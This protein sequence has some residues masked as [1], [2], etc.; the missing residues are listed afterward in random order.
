LVICWEDDGTELQGSHR[1][2]EGDPVGQCWVR[3]NDTFPKRETYSVTDQIRRAAV[4]IPSNIGEG[5]SHYSK[6]EFI[7]L[8]RH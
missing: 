3:G 6:R 4:S 2:A 8:L 5:K 1:L 7:H